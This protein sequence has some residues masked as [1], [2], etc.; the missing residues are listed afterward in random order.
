MS[1]DKEVNKCIK[2]ETNDSQIHNPIHSDDEIITK[3]KDCD[4]G[5]FEGTKQIKFD[6]IKSPPKIKNKFL[7]QSRQSE[8]KTDLSQMKETNETVSRFQEAPSGLTIE[9][10]PHSI[11]ESTLKENKMSPNVLIQSTQRLINTNE[12]FLSL[13]IFLGV[14]LL[15]ISFEFIYGFNYS[16]V[17]V[18]SDSFFNFFKTFSFLIACGS[19]LLTRVNV[20]ES[21]FLKNR[22][23]LVA[24]LANCVCLVIVSMYMCLQALHILTEEGDSLGESHNLKE[25]ET[26]IAF[27]KN[28]FVIKV[29]INVIGLLVLSDY[30][31]HPSIQIK[32]L[33]WKKHRAWKSLSNLTLENLK[34]AKSLLKIWN[35]H[36]ENLNALS[37][38]VI[39][40]LIASIL[41]LICFYISKDQ[42]YEVVYLIISL[43]NLVVICILISPVFK[44]ILRIFMQGKI[45]VYD[46]FLDKMERELSHEEGCLGIRE[47]KSWMVSQNELKCKFYL[48]IGYVRI[49]GS[50][51]IDRRKIREWINSLQ[52]NID[53]NFDLTLE[54]TN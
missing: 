47:I 13:L 30:I 23:E 7:S 8:N 37:I 12:E 46:S 20:F 44:S 53:I 48:T 36:F 42:H 26:T 2:E 32:L 29:V 21:T 14:W 6:K 3:K 15:L 38:N 19:I 22:I 1:S 54:I 49:F 25:D 31:V 10:D 9:D 27:F 50:E 33:L 52:D 17:N 11:I 16:E 34:D 41:F 18:L 35:N 5:N 43:A 39:S 45:E 4:K 28:F 51:D 24:A 40:D